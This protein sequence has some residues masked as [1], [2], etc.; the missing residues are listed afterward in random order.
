VLGPGSGEV[1][2]V[3]H[4]F[5]VLV[6]PERPLATL[7]AAAE[8]GTGETCG[9]V[10]RRM[11][12]EH[13]HLAVVRAPDGAV[14]GIVTLEDLVEELVGEIRDEHDEPGSVS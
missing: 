6:H 2:G 9:S 13:R 7:R 3:V 1:A 10:M 4:A 11:L 8:A 14:A 5:D 12:R